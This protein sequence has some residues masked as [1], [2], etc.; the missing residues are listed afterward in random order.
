MKISTVIITFNEEDN[1]ERCIKSVKPVS[2][3]VVVVDSFSTDNTKKIAIE[4]GA[5]VIENTFDGHIE[6]KNVA[7]SLA[8]F[9]WV[10]SLDADEELSETLQKSILKIK[11]GPERD[12]YSMN[13][14]TSYCGHWIRHSGWYPDTKIRLWKKEKGRW[15]GTNPHDSVILQNGIKVE[16]LKGDLLHYSYTSVSQHTIQLDKF[17]TI[18]AQEA[19]KK[20]KTL[21]P[22]I[23]IIIYP[24][25]TFL[26]AYF[27][28]LGILD[29]LYG[30]VVSISSAKYR[31][32]K[33]LKLKH[34]KEGRKI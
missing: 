15:G 2:D 6:Q 14:L 12:A 31:Y 28:K 27:L 16:K 4:L 11:L 5:R 1:I 34:L 33:Y 3:E 13:R 20:G 32:L 8:Q 30:F 18:A 25:W 23:H 26:K 29:G 22:L 19:F 9:K 21:I 10:L 24:F 7:L 17:T